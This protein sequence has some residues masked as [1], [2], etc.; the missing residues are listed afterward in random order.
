MSDIAAAAVM[1]RTASY[2]T[3]TAEFIKIMVIDRR[4]PNGARII[5]ARLPR[6]ASREPF[7]LEP[8]LCGKPPLRS[9]LAE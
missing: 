3:T 6:G 7:T 5:C 1:W 4:S 9:I 8:N 2:T